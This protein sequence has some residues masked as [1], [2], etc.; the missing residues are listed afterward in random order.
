MI[1]N[2]VKNDIQTLKDE[3]LTLVIVSSETEVL[4]M[5]GLSDEVRAESKR[6]IS[7]LQKVGIAETVMLTGDHERTAHKIADQLGIS[8]SYSNLLPE[9]KVEKLQSM[10]DQGKV[11]AMVGDG[12]NDAPALAAAD[13]GIAM[14]KG[15]D[16]AH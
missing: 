13:V 6:L 16:S 14:G 5:F 2:Q 1:P 7:A 8:T 10:M 9:E 15:T 3:G 12:I 11:V 4:G